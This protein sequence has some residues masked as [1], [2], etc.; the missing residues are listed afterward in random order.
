MKSSKFSKKVKDE[1]SENKSCTKKVPCKKQQEGESFENESKQKLAGKHPKEFL[2]S[3]SVKGKKESLQVVGKEVQEKM[4]VKVEKEKAVFSKK[5]KKEVS[6]DSDTENGSDI[7]SKAKIEVYLNDDRRDI[8]KE[9]ETKGEE[10]KRFKTFEEAFL[11]SISNGNLAPRHAAKRNYDQISYSSH[12]GKDPKSSSSKSCDDIQLE[13]KEEYNSEPEDKKS[14]QDDKKT[15]DSGETNCTSVKTKPGTVRIDPGLADEDFEKLKYQTDKFLQKYKKDKQSH[16]KG[17][18]NADVIQI[19]KDQMKKDS[20]ALVSD[21]EHNYVCK[22]K[23]AAKNLIG[24]KKSDSKSDSVKCEIPPDLVEKHKDL[25]QELIQLTHDIIQQQSSK[26]HKMIGHSNAGLFNYSKATSASSVTP[27]FGENVSSKLMQ[28]V[29][30]PSNPMYC[31]E[32]GKNSTST[33]LDFSQLAHQAEHKQAKS[34]DQLLY[35]IHKLSSSLHGQSNTVSKPLPQNIQQI[36]GSQGNLG[37]LTVDVNAGEM[38]QK[39]EPRCPAILRFGNA[40]QK[41]RLGKKSPPVSSQQKSPVSTSLHSPLNS[42][43]SQLSP[44]DR[45]LPANIVRIQSPTGLSKQI[46]IQGHQQMVSTV[47]N[48]ESLLL[49]QNVSA[50]SPP[51]L[52]PSVHTSSISF[53]PSVCVQNSVNSGVNIR[54]SQSVHNATSFSQS[55]EQGQFVNAQGFR[56]ISNGQNLIPCVTA[57]QNQT[58]VQ[59]VGQMVNPGQILSPVIVRQQFSSSFQTQNVGNHNTVISPQVIQHSQTSSNMITNPQLVTVANQ[60]VVQLGLSAANSGQARLVSN[61]NQTFL[62]NIPVMGP[63][64]SSSNNSSSSISGNVV[65]VPAGNNLVTAVSSQEKQNQVGSVVVKQ[66]KQELTSEVKPS[67]LIVASKTDNDV[68]SIIAPGSNLLQ[69]TVVNVTEKS[70]INFE[71]FPLK[72]ESQTYSPTTLVSNSAIPVNN[73]I[74]TLSAFQPLTSASVIS[75]E[76]PV[77]VPA[78][79]QEPGFAEVD[80]KNRLNDSKFEASVE[81]NSDGTIISAKYSPF[82]LEEK[83]DVSLHRKSV[84][85]S[86]PPRLQSP[87]KTM[88]LVPQPIVPISQA[89][90]SNMSHMRPLTSDNSFYNV[91]IPS[92]LLEG[93]ENDDVKPPILEMEPPMLEMEAPI[94]KLE[95]EIDSSSVKSEPDTLSNYSVGSNSMPSFRTDIDGMPV[96]PMTGNGLDSP[97]TIIQSTGYN[98]ASGMGNKTTV[99]K[100]RKSGAAEKNTMNETD[101]LSDG[102]GSGQHQV[103][104]NFF[105]SSNMVEFNFNFKKLLMHFILLLHCCLCLFA[106]R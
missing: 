71:T 77:F 5:I 84:S 90:S 25:G 39:S 103:S 22:K 60:G 70:S 46:Q 15:G 50:T 105:V 47:G 86:P 75:N 38:G 67:M 23:M 20:P 99:K 18:V 51:V 11:H 62:L 53:A 16:L 104:T 81:V 4:E 82:I 40:A 33:S 57:V 29:K 32:F 78:V 95:S 72:K 92:Q 7:K 66:E 3:D 83:S 55:T 79:K 97:S 44:V 64:T 10:K 28:S 59:E 69:G 2:K 30:N 1:K 65:H 21:N 73:V 31:T 61:G 45:S 35:T 8:K 80:D 56:L 9:S 94:L 88:Q 102:E 37:N 43:L 6:V 34:S 14:K 49:R 27:V 19:P 93:E 58:A 91:S 100:R 68:K 96:Y 24:Q 76:M 36:T 74:S 101:L 63:I 17:D 12:C 52:S 89:F 85:V 98:M 26:T 106:V 42:K 48:G 87:G 13:V 41:S 54:Q